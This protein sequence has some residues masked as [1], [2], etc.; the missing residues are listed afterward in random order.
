[1]RTNTCHF[2]GQLFDQML[3]MSFLSNIYISVAVLSGGC[4]HLRSQGHKPY[5]SMWKHTVYFPFSSYHKYV[6]PHS[7]FLAPKSSE[8]ALGAGIV[9]Y[10]SCKLPLNLCTYMPLG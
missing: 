5:V 8:I 6:Q 9:Q 7:N 3:P 4:Q 1:M 2:F 10:P